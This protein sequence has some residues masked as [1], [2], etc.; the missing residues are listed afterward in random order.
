[1]H[2]YE[3]WLEVETSALNCQPIGIDVAEAGN[4]V[5]DASVKDVRE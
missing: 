4:R 2:L 3:L 5:Q 1:M